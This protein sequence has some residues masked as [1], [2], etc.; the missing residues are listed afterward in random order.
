MG[1]ANELVQ[2]GSGNLDTCRLA[3]TNVAS[4]NLFKGFGVQLGSVEGEPMT[5]VS[6][7]VELAAS[8][9]RYGQTGSTKPVP[10]PDCCVAQVFITGGG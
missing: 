5:K 7:D 3:R 9:A 10:W 1:H 8:L 6:S 2:L 4:G